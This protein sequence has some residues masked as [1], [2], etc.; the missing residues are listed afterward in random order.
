M[1][2]RNASE[3]DLGTVD[4][5]K[6]QPL[7][8]GDSKIFNLF[9]RLP[10]L[11]GAEFTVKFLQRAL[12]NVFISDLQPTLAP[13]LFQKTMH[14]FYS[15]GLRIVRLVMSAATYHSENFK[16]KTVFDQGTMLTPSV[17]TLDTLSDSISDIKRFRFV[18][19]KSKRGT[20]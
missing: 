3:L 9:H 1:A 4:Q 11:A 6:I 8:F 20:W 19:P 18:K 12:S 13:H 7:S 17:S 15:S 14:L 10:Y 5:N 2:R 16:L